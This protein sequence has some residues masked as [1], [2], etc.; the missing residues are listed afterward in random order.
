MSAARPRSSFVAAASREEAARALAERHGPPDEQP[1]LRA[2]L[3]VRRQVQMGDVNWIV[4]NPETI[5]YFM[6]RNDEWQLIRL[7]D[8]S[9]TRQQILE[10]YNRRVRN[11]IPMNLVLSYEDSL[12]RM[13]LLEQSVVEKNL[14]LLDMSSHF[15]RKKAEQK[16]EGFN[17]FFI[18]FHLID[19]DRFLTRTVKYVRWIWTPPVVA[20]VL[21]ASLWTVTIFAQHGTQIWAE[22]L[23]LYK[24]VGKP[25]L[26][27]LQFFS[28]LIIIGAIHEF[29]HGYVVKIY[30]GEVHD[31]GMAL[32]YFTPVFY[33]ET[34]DSF[35]FTNKW[36]KLW[37][38]VAGIYVEAGICS[39]ATI[40]WVASYPDTVLHQLAYKTMLL[41]GFATVFFNINPL[42]KVDGY[43]ALASFLEMPGMREGA[44]RL[45]SQSFQ[46]YALRLPIEIP[47]MAPRKKLVYWIYGTLSVGYT[48]TIMVVIGGWVS[49]FY[50]KFFPDFAVVLILITLYYIFR[51]RVRQLTRV[52]RLM[53]LDKKELLMS[54][55]SRTWLVAAGVVILLVLFVPWSHRTIRGDAVLRPSTKAV[56]EA[57]EDSVVAEVLVREGDSVERGQPIVR[58]VSPTADEQERRM[59]VERN[60]YEKESNRAREAA[61]AALTYQARQ[62]AESADV[63]WRSSE[64]RRNYLT[65]RSPIAGRVLTHRPEDL[66]ARFVVEGA[67]LVEIGDC[68][69]M[70]AEVGV[71][72]RLL[73]YLQ[74]GARATALIQSSPMRSQRGSVE[75]ISVA[76]AGLPPTVKGGIDPA[77]PSALPERFTAVAVF[78]NPDGQLL[79]GAV[80]KVKIRSDREGYALRAWKVFWR[81]LRAILW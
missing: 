34:S 36:H 75:R 43:N 3:R 50:N 41:T 81:W 56:L 38:T 6:F 79:P 2:D 18:M 10:D 46:K 59:A 76:T 30:G 44:F 33:C 35:M 1:A 58:L 47:P 9:R 24:F 19:P 57:P 32:F 39:I 65:L 61:D 73:S 78:D 5:K 13:Q 74:P 42:I 14:A 67:D 25:L 8:G 51:K 17:I 12:R 66:S 52:A 68:R 16:S 37:V 27:I 54:P 15:K 26:D 63:G 48:A 28:I 80:A 77:A 20:V 31:I 62:R 23:Q 7:F 45:I 4:K 72:E 60:L 29:S 21:A 64:S 22:T 11:P 55:R 70:V 49:N 69:R 40:L 71:S 53:Y